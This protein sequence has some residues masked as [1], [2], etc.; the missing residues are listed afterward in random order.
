MSET[1]AIDVEEVAPLPPASL[2]F[3]FAQQFSVLLE[4]GLDGAPVIVHEGAPT[5]DV[6]TELRR[7]LGEP[8]TL[9]GVVLE[10][11][12]SVVRTNGVVVRVQ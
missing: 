5:V 2:P 8:F 10:S 12:T 11:A 7:L 4:R 3:T 1:P 9:Q 6:L